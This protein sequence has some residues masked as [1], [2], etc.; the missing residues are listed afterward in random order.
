MPLKVQP[1]ELTAGFAGVV[2]LCAS[3]IGA[4]DNNTAPANV[5]SHDEVMLLPLGSRYVVWTLSTSVK[6]PTDQKVS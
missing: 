3:T 2:V 1:E 4:D 6:R 5:A